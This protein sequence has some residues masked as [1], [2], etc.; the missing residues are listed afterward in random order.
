MAQ[1]ANSTVTELKGNH[2]IYASQPQAI[3]AVIEKAA[4][5]LSQ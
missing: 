5:S 3:A 4:R 2:A 1:R